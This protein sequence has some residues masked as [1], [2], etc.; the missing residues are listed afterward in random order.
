MTDFFLTVGEF[1]HLAVT[2]GES[3][4][5]G[6]FAALDLEKARRFFESPFLGR[7]HGSKVRATARPQSCKGRAIAKRRRDSAA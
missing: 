2:A 6:E 7:G 1:D 4:D 3:L 5:L